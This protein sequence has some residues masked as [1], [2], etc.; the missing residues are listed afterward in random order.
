MRSRFIL[1]Q[2]AHITDDT[3]ESFD[4]VQVTGALFLDLNAAYDSIWLTDLHLKIQKAI[5]CRKATD[6]I[7]NFLCNRSFVLFS[8][9][10]ASKPY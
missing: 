7:M 1:D 5:S 4:V 2:V 9:G 8:D 3:E 6:L 10:E